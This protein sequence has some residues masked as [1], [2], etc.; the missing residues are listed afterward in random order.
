MSILG[1]VGPVL[2]VAALLLGDGGHE[3]PY[4]PVAVNLNDPCTLLSGEAVG[5][6]FGVNNVRGVP[7]PARTAANGLPTH[8]CDYRAAFPDVSLGEL[9][10][11]VTDASVTPAQV[12]E[13]WQRGKPGARPIPGV[14]QAAVYYLDQQN[15]TGMVAAAKSTPA[16]TVAVIYGGSTRAS[17][18]MLASLVKQAIDTV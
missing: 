1:R 14:G 3:R 17:Q 9:L 18:D 7:K 15:K 2:A 11:A 10:T 8:S 5:R 16:G 13:A 12:A 4:T 6:V